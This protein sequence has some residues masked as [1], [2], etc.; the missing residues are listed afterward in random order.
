LAYRA[1]IDA[2]ELTDPVRVGNA[3]FAKDCEAEVKVC[4]R[5]IKWVE[6]AGT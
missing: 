4:R 2:G 3:D 1:S 5:E 6:D